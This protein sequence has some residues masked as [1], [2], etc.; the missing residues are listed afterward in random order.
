M[1]IRQFIS[2][3]LL[4][5]ATSSV[6]A[7]VVKIDL[8]VGTIKPGES[9]VISLDKLN[10]QHAYNLSCVLTS[11]HASGQPYNLVHVTTPTNSSKINVNAE[12]TV[13]GSHQY[14]LPTDKNSYVTGSITKEIGD[15]AILNMD[16]TD[17]IL[18]SSCHAVGRT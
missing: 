8:N 16:T 14:K 3:L 17:T 2:A 13:P 1:M 9:M 7:G 4:L 15:I 12:E 5:S 6:S 11:D 10:P 18:L